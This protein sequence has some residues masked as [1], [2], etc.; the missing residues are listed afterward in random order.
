MT[1]AWTSLRSPTV[2]LGKQV[3]FSEAQLACLETGE[4]MLVLPPTRWLRAQ[5][6]N[7][8]RKCSRRRHFV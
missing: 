1:V 5:N 6:E 4:A 8:L 2:S 3:P 7:L